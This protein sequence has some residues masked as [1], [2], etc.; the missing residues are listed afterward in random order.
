MAFTPIGLYGETT[1][2]TN[3]SPGNNVGSTKVSLT[4]AQVLGTEPSNLARSSAYA[5][6]IISFG[7]KKYFEFQAVQFQTVPDF[8]WRF[9]LDVAGLE[10]PNTDLGQFT[11]QIGYAKGGSIF[12]SGVS[13]TFGGFV[14]REGDVVGFAVDYTTAT[15][16]TV[17]AFLN[18]VLQ[19]SD[20]YTITS[21]IAF[22]PASTIGVFNILGTEINLFTATSNFN[23]S[24]P[25]GFAPLESSSL[26]SYTLSTNGQA[27]SNSGGDISAQWWTLTP[28]SG[29]GTNYQ[30]MATIILNQTDSSSTIT[31]VF[32]QFTSLSTNQTWS[33]E[34]AV[35][36]D[37]FSILVQIRDAFTLEVLGF[38]TI[39]LG[40]VSP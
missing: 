38:A 7:D 11:N 19:Q 2:G 4:N 8:F 23:F 20:T 13:D 16:L 39:A 31:G 35:K 27:S 17:N 32:G 1:I 26:A 36:T 21:G 24:P 40:I 12:I 34:S 15:S 22:R 3:S 18:N 30:V 29:V 10:F 25:T 6:A 33:V 37:G 28:E 9:G 5:D 14:Y